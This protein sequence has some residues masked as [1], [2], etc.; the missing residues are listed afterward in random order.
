MED[1]AKSITDE[2]GGNAGATTPDSMVTTARS[3]QVV[4]DFFASVRFSQQHKT[5]EFIEQDPEIVHVLGM[6][7]FFLNVFSC[8][9]LDKI[10]RRFRWL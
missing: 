7:Y 10:F 1:A 8:V 3:A 6:D 5:A 9:L 4:I 2:P